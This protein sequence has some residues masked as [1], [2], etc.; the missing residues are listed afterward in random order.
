MMLL[1]LICD[2]W[3]PEKDYTDQGASD[4]NQLKGSGK[5]IVHRLQYDC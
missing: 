2:T 1:M 3:R 5:K 4:S